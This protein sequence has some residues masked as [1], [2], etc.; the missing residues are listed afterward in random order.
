M[1][2]LVTGGSGMVGQ[3]LSD[4]I[5]TE[6]THTYVFLS[7]KDCDLRDWAAVRALFEKERPDA[8]I[9]LAAN[10]GG[11]Y[12]NMRQK[13]RMFEDNVRLNMNVVQ[14]CVQYGAKKALFVL[15]SC[16]FPAQVALPMTERD[17]HR[18][19]PHASNEGYAYAKRM[20]E[21]HV[22]LCREAYG[23]AYTCLSPVN[24]YGPYD[25]FATLDSHV[26]PGMMR[27]FHES[28]QRG[29]E[30]VVVYGSGKPMR[31]FLYAPDFADIL[32]FYLHN[33][34]KNTPPHVICCNDE[35]IS[36]TTLA[37]CLARV[38]GIEPSAIV[39]DTQKSDGCMRKT[40]SNHMLQQTYGKDTVNALT[41]FCV[42]IAHTYAWFKAHQQTLRQ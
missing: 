25:N 42:G 7:S 11:L 32:L 8:V 14:A 40:V 4:A 33:M 2:V 24:L 22:R 31:Q 39:Y 37:E 1:H 28:V 12:K 17:L 38:V 6:T 20:L 23:L 10:V 16:V 21:V 30:H 29:D 18:G 13:P 19:P 36:I 41:P 5:Q 3:C 15:S 34:N 26:I 35:E 27:R 9:H